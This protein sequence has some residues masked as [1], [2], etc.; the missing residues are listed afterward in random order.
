MFALGA[1]SRSG[2]EVTHVSPSRFGDDG[3]VGHGAG[4]V[5]H[6]KVSARRPPSPQPAAKRLSR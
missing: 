5:K 6:L 2:E 3:E 1:L 4:G